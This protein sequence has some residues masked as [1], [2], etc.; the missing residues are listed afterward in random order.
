V[1]EAQAVFDA[2][3]EPKTLIVIESADHIYKGKEGE[4]VNKAMEWIKTT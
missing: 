2:A 1:D 3:N 4:L